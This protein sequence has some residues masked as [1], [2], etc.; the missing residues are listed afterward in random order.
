MNETCT[1]PKCD[2]PVYII[3]LHKAVCEKHWFKYS[4][5]KLKRKLFGVKDES[6]K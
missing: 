6:D 3:Y 5:E 2:R 4:R 1:I